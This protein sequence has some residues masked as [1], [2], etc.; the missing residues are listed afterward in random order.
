MASG[1]TAGDDGVAPETRRT[2][3]RLAGDWGGLRGSLDQHGIRFDLWT[4]G[5]TQ[6]MFQG[7]GEDAGDLSSRADRG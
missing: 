2:R 7:T 6:G 5:F 1:Q 3:D 4:T